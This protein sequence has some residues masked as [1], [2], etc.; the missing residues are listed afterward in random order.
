MKW[1]VDL[2]SFIPAMQ[3]MYQPYVPGTNTCLWGRSHVFGAALQQQ[4]GGALST[5]DRMRNRRDSEIYMMWEL[6]GEQLNKHTTQVPKMG[7]GK[8]YIG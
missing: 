1:P 5:R 2:D 6:Y 3:A 4:L 8:L 7:F